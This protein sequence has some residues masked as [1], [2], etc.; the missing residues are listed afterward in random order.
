LNWDD[1]SD[2]P[3]DVLDIEELP[4]G[5]LPAAL[6]DDQEDSD[7]SDDD[8]SD[9]ENDESDEPSEDSLQALAS[10]E[11]SDAGDKI[12]GTEDEEN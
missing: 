11:A 10:E 3:L 2:E 9:D 8:D 6:A 7:N 12:P 5:E 1:L 4:G